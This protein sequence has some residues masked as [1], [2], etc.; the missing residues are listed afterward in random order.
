MQKLVKLWK[1]IFQN[2]PVDLSLNPAAG[3]DPLGRGS[4]HLLSDLP[5][6][7]YKKLLQKSL[8]EFL[9]GRGSTGWTTLSKILNWTLSF[10]NIC[11]SAS[12][13]LG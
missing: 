12:D 7:E 11:R 4:R 5:K 13:S 8:N 10:Q 9:K 1:G 3:A 6:V 2:S